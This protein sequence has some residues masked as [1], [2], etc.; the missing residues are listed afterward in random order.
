M[1]ERKSK[2]IMRFFKQRGEAEDTLSY[3]YVELHKSERKIAKNYCSYLHSSRFSIYVYVCFT[4][5]VWYK[6]EQLLL[7]ALN[8]G[9]LVNDVV[10]GIAEV[11][12]YASSCLGSSLNA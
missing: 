9:V 12:F 10:K 2:A 5:G 6:L 7:F 4:G 1:S 3:D 11:L 8:L